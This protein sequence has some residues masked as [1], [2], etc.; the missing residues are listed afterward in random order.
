[1]INRIIRHIVVGCNYTMDKVV[2]SIIIIFTLLSCSVD[3]KDYSLREELSENGV[4]RFYKDFDIFSRQ[5]HEEILGDTLKIPFFQVQLNNDSSIKLTIFKKDFEKEII[6]PKGET[7]Q[8]D[9]DDIYDG[10]RH[11]YYKIFKDSIVVF[12][13]DKKI[14]EVEKWQVDSAVF[15][16]LLPRQ[17]E[18]LTGDTLY[19]YLQE[20]LNIKTTGNDESEL[21]IP[22]KDFLRFSVQP[23]SRVIDLKCESCLI[24]YFD[25][26]GAWRHY[27][28]YFEGAE[29]LSKRNPGDGLYGYK[30]EFNY[31]RDYYIV[32]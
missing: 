30:K 25:T 31:W 23:F 5:G 1:V 7:I 10:P 8:Y 18:I 14:D 29:Y 21:E 16:D 11:N 12:G 28:R 27:Y 17:I 22:K 2:I 24:H 15:Y 13:Y 20:C 32:D 3:R 26:T 6:V 9:F 19:I 4:A